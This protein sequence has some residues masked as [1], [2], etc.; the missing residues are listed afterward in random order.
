MSK[1]IVLIIC[2]FLSMTAYAV[3]WLSYTITVNQHRL[4]YYQAGKGKPLFLLTGYAT[5]SNFWSKPFVNCLAL[6]HTVYLVDYWGINT[7]EK[8]PGNVS[9]QAMA[10]DS[11][12]ISTALKVK[13]PVFVGWSMGGAV[14]EQIGFSYGD[15]LEKI[16]LISPVTMTN[17]PAADSSPKRTKPFK[18]FDDILNYVFDNNLYG[19]TPKQLK[20]YKNNLFAKDEQLFP[21]GE[22]SENQH[23]AMNDWSISPATLNEAK[24]SEIKYLFMVPKQDRILD[25]LHT[26]KD[27][28][29]FP[30][31]KVIEFDGSGHN[32]SMQDPD[33]VCKQITNFI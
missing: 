10:D 14:A 26:I 20:M 33:E 30:D 29:N 12:A 21:G 8:V 2:L 11:Y 5:T 1:K 15:N 13:N 23:T 28:S 3:D 32:I 18:N 24:K 27:A 31:A 9:I 7:D 6:D 16:V 19:Y 17:Q 25:P 22:I 4:H